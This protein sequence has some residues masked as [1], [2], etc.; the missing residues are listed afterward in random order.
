MTALGAQCVHPETQK[1]YIKSISGGKNISAEQVKVRMFSNNFIRE[2]E[3]YLH[4]EDFLAAHLC[5][6]SMAVVG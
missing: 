5:I 6:Y 1:S 2:H 3:P 4:S